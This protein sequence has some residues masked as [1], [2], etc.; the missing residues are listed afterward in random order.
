MD[1]TPKPKAKSKPI[2]KKLLTSTTEDITPK[3]KVNSTPT[4]KNILTPTT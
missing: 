2:L 1:I 4:L 3:P